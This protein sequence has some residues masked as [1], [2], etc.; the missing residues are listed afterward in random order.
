MFFLCLCLVWGFRSYQHLG[1]SSGGRDDVLG[2]FYF[3]FRLQLCTLYRCACFYFSIVVVQFYTCVWFYFW[4]HSIE[5][6][7]LELKD[8]RSMRF[9]WF[10]RLLLYCNSAALSA[11]TN[12]WCECR[13][14]ISIYK[15]MV[16][17][18]QHY[19]HILIHGV[20]AAALSAYTNMSSYKHCSTISVYMVQKAAA[21][22]VYTNMCETWL[23][24]IFCDS[25]TMLSL[26]ENIY[27]SAFVVVIAGD[28]FHPWW[29][30]WFKVGKI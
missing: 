11:Y 16:R 24:D 9:R 10:A 6:I 15:C 18:P 3:L 30:W 21:L 22:S 26:Q 17:M 2:S 19:Q 23:P 12:T 20:N 14:T 7:L 5:E 8:A 4:Y 25:L 27:V 28:S 13:S 1:E 29:K